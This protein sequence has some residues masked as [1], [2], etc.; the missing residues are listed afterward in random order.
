V[1]RSRLEILVGFFV[2]LALV[3]L[4]FM[5]F[6]VSGIYV[7]RK[8]YH[9]DVVFNF[10]S[11]L[12]KGAIV[13]LAGIPVGNVSDLSIQFDRTR[14]KPFVRVRLFVDD[15]IVIREG[16]K[17]R[18]QGIYG[19]ATPHLEIETGADPKARVLTQGDIIEGIDPVPIEDLVVKG[20]RIVEHLEK[21]VVRINTFIEEPE[22]M[23]SLRGTL[24]HLNALTKNLNAIL[25][26]K[27]TDVTQ[28]IEELEQ[29]TASLRRILGKIEKGEGTAGKLIVDETLYRELEEFVKDL[30]QHP[31]KLLKKDGK[32]KGRFLG[33]F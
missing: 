33:I 9:V 10:V 27:H 25:T 7:F 3:I 32:T 30:R 5:V 14:P 8:G 23:D 29:A 21:T 28:T 26:E 16:A 18:I 6:F 20:Q 17:A 1:R 11:R 24:I 15:G 4:A 19:L 2:I 31:W 13:Q 12:E 22:V